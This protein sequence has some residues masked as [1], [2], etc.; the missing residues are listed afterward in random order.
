MI[1]YCANADC[2]F[3]ECY[4]HLSKVKELD[5]DSNKYVNVADYS[6]V[7]RDYIGYLIEGVEYGFV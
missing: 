2:P 7:Y 6:G 1:T 3:K 4:R 5:R